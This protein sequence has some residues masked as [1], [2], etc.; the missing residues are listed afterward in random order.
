MWMPTIINIKW[1]R[2]VVLGS[3]NDEEGSLVKGNAA[4]IHVYLVVKVRSN[5]LVLFCAAQR[6]QQN[7]VRV[8]CIEEGIAEEQRPSLRSAVRAILDGADSNKLKA[9]SIITL[10]DDAVRMMFILQASSSMS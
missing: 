7:E 1:G 3:E 9:R 8:C 2:E 4:G 10:G 6:H 5:L